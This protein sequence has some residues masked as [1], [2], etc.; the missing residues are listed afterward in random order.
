HNDADTA[1][2]LH[3]DARMKD[4][5]GNAAPAGMFTLPQADITVPAHGAA[6]AHLVADTRVNAPDGSYQGYVVATGGG[7]VVHTPV[8]LSREVESYDVTVRA[9]GPDGGPATDYGA[10]FTN[11]AT[12]FEPNADG[13]TVRLPKGSYFVDDWIAVPTGSDDWS[14]VLG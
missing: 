7:A 8:A 1:L 5:A 4:P 2:P 13:A 6:T 10:G 14:Y 9:I 3:L 11:V 12:G